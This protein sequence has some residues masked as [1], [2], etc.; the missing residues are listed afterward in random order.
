MYSGSGSRV[1][2][3]RERRRLKKKTGADKKRSRDPLNTASCAA[4][5]TWVLYYVYVC[6]THVNGGASRI[7]SIAVR[8]RDLWRLYHV[9]IYIYNEK[10]AKTVLVYI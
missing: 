2:K 10:R 4:T 3:K 5:N 8:A 9:Y 1:K 7:F 6:I